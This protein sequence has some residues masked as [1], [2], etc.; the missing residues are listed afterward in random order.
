MKMA[1]QPPP[2]A[3]GEPPFAQVQE[4]YQA[5]PAQPQQN[6]PAAAQ[7]IPQQQPSEYTPAPPQYYPG[8]GVPQ[9]PGYPY[10][11]QSVQNS[12]VSAA[13]SMIKINV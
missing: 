12:N 4:G 3:P 13:T 2:Y 11:A 6:K 1:A 8:Q 7:S 5:V 9:Q 10:A